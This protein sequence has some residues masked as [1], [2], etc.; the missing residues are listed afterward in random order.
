MT[1]GCY[2]AGAGTIFD[3]LRAKKKICVLVNSK[4]MGNH[5]IDLVSAMTM[6]HCLLQ[7]EATPAAVATVVDK[8]VKFKPAVFPAPEPAKVSS[9]VL[10]ESSL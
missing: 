5:Q 8:L 2:R 10:G 3:C 4:L 1:T 7:A 9:I 6:R